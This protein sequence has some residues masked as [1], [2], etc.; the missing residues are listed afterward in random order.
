MARK[1]PVTKLR[2]LLL[3]VA[4]AAALMLSLGL[5]GCAGAYPP[6]RPAGNFPAQPPASP[7]ATVARLTTTLP[8]THGFRDYWTCPLPNGAKLICKYRDNRDPRVVTEASMTVDT[9]V[10]KFNCDAGSSTI[11]WASNQQTRIQQPDFLANTWSAATWAAAYLHQLSFVVP[12]A[13]GHF[14][15]EAKKYREAETKPDLPESA[16]EF[17]VR[18]ESAVKEKRFLDAVE[19][20]DRALQVAPW[21]PQGHF[22][23]ALILS[24]LKV[25]GLAIDEMQRY[26]L[27]T[28]DAENARQAQDKIYDW[29]GRL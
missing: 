2:S 27:L 15:A 26:L 20:F 22:N 4:P 18:A 6:Y 21:W 17:K 24:E 23:A 16:R 11:K 19:A 14:E 5:T 13:P 7:M 3:T 25:Y 8:G 29:K 1:N 12:E 10:L 28:P 9:V